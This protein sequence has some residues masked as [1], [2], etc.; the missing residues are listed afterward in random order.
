MPAST[1]RLVSQQQ[2]AC[3]PPPPGG[4]PTD[5]TTVPCGAV[6]MTHGHPS[7]LIGGSEESRLR[8]RTGATSR[9]SAGI[10]CHLRV[11]FVMLSE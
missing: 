5:A 4:Q 1:L 10:A 6:T 7:G 2:E 8:P 11:L 9:T 3:Q